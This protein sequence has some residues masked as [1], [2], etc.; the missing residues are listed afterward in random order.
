MTSLRL[1]ASEKGPQ[2]A[3]EEAKLIP[4]LVNL[5]ELQLEGNIKIKEDTFNSIA[6]YP[7]LLSIHLG[8]LAENYYL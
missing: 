8:G 2:M 1:N 5:V 7:S 3:D 6:R 4:Y